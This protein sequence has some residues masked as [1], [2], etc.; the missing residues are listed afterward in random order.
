MDLLQHYKTIKL[1]TKKDIMKE[2]ERQLNMVLYNLPLESKYL[3]EIDI[4]E[5]F[6]SKTK[7][8]QYWLYTLE[9][10]TPAGERVT[11]SQKGI[12][13]DGRLINLTICNPHQE[14]N[15]CLPQRSTNLKQK[16][17]NSM[18]ADEGES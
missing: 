2:I 4:T 8:Q 7:R 9:A 1:G 3:L 14:M 15:P 12:M 13:K 16:H 5:L 10:A 18:P 6:Q 11:S 17:I